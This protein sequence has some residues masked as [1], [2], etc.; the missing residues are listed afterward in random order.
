[1]D[2]DMKMLLARKKMLFKIKQEKAEIQKYKEYFVKNIEHFQE[3]YRY[4]DETEVIKIQNFISK[5]NFVQPG[6]L[7]IGDVCPYFHSNIYLCFLM[8]T[9]ALFKI[10]IFGRYDDIM[11]DYGEWEVFSPYLL[12]VDEDFSHYVYINDYGDVMESQVM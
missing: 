12:L 11:N 4:A 1:M 8:G 2:D 6:Q 7:A 10:Y 9:K 5:L 3:K